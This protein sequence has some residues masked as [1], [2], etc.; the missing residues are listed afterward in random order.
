MQT[1]WLRIAV[2]VVVAIVVHDG[3]M[4]TAGHESLAV[5]AASQGPA[6]PERHSDAHRHHEADALADPDPDASEMLEQCGLLRMAASLNRDMSPSLDTAAV[7]VMPESTGLTRFASASRTFVE[8][9][10]PHPSNLNRSFFQVYR[11]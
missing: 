8:M 11:I 3:W 1:S 4:A 10:P 5:M 9:P 2:L 7:G 6:E